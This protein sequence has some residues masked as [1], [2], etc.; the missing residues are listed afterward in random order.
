MNLSSFGLG[1]S[2]LNSDANKNQNFVRLPYNNL[3]APCGSFLS[4]SNNIAP[5]W[6]GPVYESLG[7]DPI[8]FS[9][10]YI[11]QQFMVL[12]H[13]QAQEQQRLETIVNTMNLMYLQQLRQ[14]QI[15]IHCN[16]YMLQQH[17]S[18]LS[19]AN[20]YL[21]MLPVAPI[22]I[23]SEKFHASRTSA[24]TKVTP[25]NRLNSPTGVTSHTSSIDCADT[26]ENFLQCTNTSKKRKAEDD[27]KDTREQKNRTN[28]CK[29]EE[30][31]NHCYFYCFHY[32]Y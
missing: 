3:M 20:N 31:T 27:A 8:A 22:P 32:F 15:E 25:T 4:A 28:F 18:L 1:V 5:T 11:H 2:D 6:N 24:F 26:D 9:T 12:M 14:Q 30:Y 29:V 16:Q 13:Q 7:I 19:N 23:K 21:S 10:A 17:A